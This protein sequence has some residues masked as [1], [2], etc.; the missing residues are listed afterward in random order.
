MEPNYT[1]YSKEELEQA[2]TTI[3][4]AAFPDRTLRIKHEIGRRLNENPTTCN[5]STPSHRWTSTGRNILL[6]LCFCLLTMLALTA[7]FSGKTE[8]IILFVFSVSLTTF[9]AIN[10]FRKNDWVQID[11]SGVKYKNILGYKHLYWNEIA[12]CKIRYLRYTKSAV[13]IGK[14]GGEY[15]LPVTGRNAKEITE[16]VNAKLHGNVV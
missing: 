1:D 6:L 12:T 11:E 4:Q 5:A 15:A 2:L 8:G 9:F 16:V 7:L 3:D 13:L 10:V 14:T